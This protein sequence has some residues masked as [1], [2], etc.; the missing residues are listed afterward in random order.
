MRDANAPLLEQ[1]VVGYGIQLC[2]V[3]QYLHTHNPPIIFRDL[4]PSNIMRTP[5]GVMKLIDFGVARTYKANRR[6]DTIAMGSAGYAPPEQYGTKQTDARSDIYALG[7][8]LLHVLTNLPPVPLQTPAPGSIRRQNPSVDT[9]T[10]EV[11]IKAMALDRE[12]RFASCAEMEGA[13]MRCLDGPYVDPTV[14]VAPPPPA[15]P[16]HIPTPEVTVATERVL[17]NAQTA[18][19]SSRPTASVPTQIAPVIANNP[20]VAP[21]LVPD[22]IACARCGRVN[23]KGARFCAACGAPLA[24]LPTPRLMINSPRGSLELKLEHMPSRIGRRDPRQNHYPE[25]DLAEYD[26]GIASRH[27]ATIARDGDHYTVMDLGSTNGTM[28][29][30]VLLPPKQPKTLRQ[31]DRIKVGEVEMEFRWS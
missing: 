25:V 18:P 21:Q 20:V 14:L 5:E 29:N 8:T 31:G 12:Q 13:L 15:A 23:K 28:L 3:L 27:H 24:G 10:E 26:R 11:I 9:Q 30:G 1:Q 16:V 7:A 22:G 2:R 19:A 6:K 17:S 4:K